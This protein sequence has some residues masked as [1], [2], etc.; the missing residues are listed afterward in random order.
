MANE[1]K[2]TL[3]LTERGRTLKK[4]AISTLGG[5][6][7]SIPVS[8]H[9][10]VAERGVEVREA[11]VDVFKG[12]SDHLDHVETREHVLDEG[13]T[14]WG[15]AGEVTDGDRRPVIDQMQ[16][17]SPDLKDGAHAGDVVNVPVEPDSK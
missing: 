9:G 13:E 5:L 2:N 10:Q 8:V 15:L 12:D 16:S 1:N 11:V 14:L 3:Q 4:I 6:A 7:I 17:L